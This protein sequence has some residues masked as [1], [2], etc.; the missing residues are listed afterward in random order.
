MVLYTNFSDHSS[1]YFDQGAFSVF[2]FQ[3]GD[4]PFIPRKKPRYLLHTEGAHRPE[5]AWDVCKFK[6]FTIS[7]AVNPVIVV[8]GKVEGDE[9]TLIIF[10]SPNG[11]Q[12]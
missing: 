2:R 6:D 9:E 10:S 1:P 3:V 11:I 5:I 8:R 7:N 12:K 4:Y